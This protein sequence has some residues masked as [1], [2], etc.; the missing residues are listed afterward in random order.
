[1]SVSYSPASFAL[2]KSA[3]DRTD[4]AASPAAHAR[5]SPICVGSKVVNALT[6]GTDAAITAPTHTVFRFID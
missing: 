6:T 5:Q 3:S 4:A 2:T 1:M